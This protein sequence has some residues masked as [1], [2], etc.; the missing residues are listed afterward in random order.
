MKKLAGVHI[1]MQLLGFNRD[2]PDHG[3]ARFFERT[4]F[5]PESVCVLLFHADFVHLHRGMETEYTLFDDNCA[6]HG[7]PFNKE[8]ARQPW[9]N[10]D[11]RDLIAELKKYGVAFYA[12]IMGSYLGDLFHHEWLSDHPEVRTAER[13]QTGYLHCLKRLADGT[14]YED[15]FSKKLVETLDDYGCEGVHIA[16]SF[17][18]TSYLYQ[19]DYSCDMLDQFRAYRG[20]S[21]PEELSETLGDDSVE[22]C[23]FRGGYIWEH[24]R[25]E[26]TRFY[27]WRWT[28][29]F[30]KVCTAAHAHDHKVSVLGMYCTDP[31]ETRMI[32][33]F[34][35]AAVMKAGV[36]RLTA[37]IL[38]TS[39]AMNMPDR[40]YF[41][42]RFHMD[43][44]LVKAQIGNAHTVSMLGVQDASEEWSVLA[45]A[46]SKLE[47]DLYTITSMR[48]FRGEDCIPSMEGI[49]I[50]LGDGVEP[51]EWAFLRERLEIGLGTDAEKAWSPVILYSEQAEDRLIPEYIR[52]RRTSPH[53]QSFEIF[54]SGTPFAGAVRTDELD[55]FAGTLFVPNFDLLTDAERAD[56]LKNGSAFVGTVPAGFDLTGV[57]GLRVTYACTDGY[58]DYPMTAFVSGA[59]ISAEV[60]SA[61][62]EML[63]ED[64]GKAN[65]TEINDLV[66]PLKAQIPF[67]KL[68]DGFVKA[69]GALL[70]ACMRGNFPVES[71]VPMMALRLKNGCD[72]LYLYNPHEQHYAQGVVTSDEPIV[73]A[74]VASAYPV[75]PVRFV[76]AMNTGFTFDRKAQSSHKRFQCKLAPAG[77][78]VV[79]IKRG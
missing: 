8:R 60:Q 55:G 42:H 59:E 64:D 5:I 43:T 45:H 47:R 68:S 65:L 3:V 66:N 37:N 32:Y 9:T 44:P 38:P 63:S 16:D 31:F 54:K 73:E 26:Y 74:K 30:E 24:L 19:G 52:T 49:F 33:G 13:T 58:S 27:E 79:D 72:R 69:C 28:K 34:N 46:P 12:G 70:R 6:Y 40:E 35:T 1:W 21:L 76:D 53:K 17:C 29:F 41:F 77:V 62:S 36:D 4:G 2:D 67:R 61:V 56:L 39:V 23:D 22:A 71:S 20:G 18:P 25:E 10:Y 14:Y 57:E 7:I 78:T 11:L 75:L 50:C 51:H 15:F 48:N